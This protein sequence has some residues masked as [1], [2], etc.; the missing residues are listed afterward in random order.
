MCVYRSVC[1]VV[2]LT[3][4]HEGIGENKKKTER[5]KRG[6]EKSEFLFSFSAFMSG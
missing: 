4:C 5:K 1:V 6:D 3:G 2:S